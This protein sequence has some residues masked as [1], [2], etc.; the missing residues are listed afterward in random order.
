MVP[1]ISLHGFSVHPKHPLPSDMAASQRVGDERT[2]P[3]L[4]VAGC[5][6]MHDYD[7]TGEE[8]SAHCSS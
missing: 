8:F 6:E 7:S 5:I 2:L 3:F 4:L 1:A